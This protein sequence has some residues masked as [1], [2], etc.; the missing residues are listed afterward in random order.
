MATVSPTPAS[1]D[2]QTAP[3]EDYGSIA[4]TQEDVHRGLPGPW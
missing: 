2:S 1:D 4:Y 3:G